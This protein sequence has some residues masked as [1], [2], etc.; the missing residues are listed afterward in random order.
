MRRLVEVGAWDVRGLPLLAQP[1]P[2]QSYAP[3]AA[4]PAPYS[5]E[6]P[7]QWNQAPVTL[8]YQ[9]KNKGGRDGGKTMIQRLNKESGRQENV[10]PNTWR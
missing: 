8:I 5:Y 4:K 1:A 2:R 6:P 7:C 9:W 3:M 10:V